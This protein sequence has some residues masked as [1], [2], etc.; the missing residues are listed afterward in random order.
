ML[1]LAFLVAEHLRH[2]DH[3]LAAAE[4]LRG[5]IGIRAEQHQVVE[6]VLHFL[7]IAFGDAVV[8][9]VQL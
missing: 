9:E 4:E 2:L 5:V 7:G 8:V 6:G 1:R 3:G